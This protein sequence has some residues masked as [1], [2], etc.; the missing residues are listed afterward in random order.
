M[1]QQ[2]AKEITQYMA[3]G[4]G[5]SLVSRTFDLVS[6]TSE[7]LELTFFRSLLLLAAVTPLVCSAGT[8]AAAQG[9]DAVARGRYLVGRV[10]VCGDCH[11]PRIDGKLDRAHWLEGAVFPYNPR[12]GFATFAPRIA[13][14]P[15]GWTKE[16]TVRFL[17]TG[18]RPDGTRARP[19]MPAYQLNSED[20]TAVV[21]YLESLRK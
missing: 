1:T 21:G 14:L 7:T 12:P 4:D 10:A 19:P 16:Q 2:M 11:T 13:G 5:E 15:A 6:R 8:A 20:A 18:I 9:R 17:Q 3:G